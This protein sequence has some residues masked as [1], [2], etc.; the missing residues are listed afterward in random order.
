M[1]GQNVEGV[2]ERM[3][4]GEGWGGLFYFSEQPGNAG[5]QEW[6]SYATQTGWGIH[7]GWRL[8][9]AGFWARLRSMTRKAACSVLSLRATGPNS[10]KKIPWLQ[11]N[12]CASELQNRT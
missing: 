1:F 12:T 11:Q 5:R 6:P 7:S 4:L 2:W 9:S 3:G 10:G 8:G